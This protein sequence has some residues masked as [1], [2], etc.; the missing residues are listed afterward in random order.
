MDDD[1]FINLRIVRNWIHGHGPVFNV[2]ERVEAATSPLWLGLLALLGELRISL[3]LGAVF[4]GIVLTVAA[5]LLAQEASG[6]LHRAR[7][8][9][10]ERSLFPGIPLGAAISRPCRRCGTTR[11]RGSRPV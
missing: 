11:R 1:G 7:A 8:H 2:D 9:V 5:L 4:A 10:H 6:G 3:E